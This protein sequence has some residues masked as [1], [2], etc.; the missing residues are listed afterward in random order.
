MLVDCLLV[1]REVHKMYSNERNIFA[2][3]DN[4]MKLTSTLCI[5]HKI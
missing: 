2:L 1:V 5:L 3:L 4:Y